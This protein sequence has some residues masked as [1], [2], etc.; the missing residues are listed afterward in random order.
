[1]IIDASAIVAITLHEPEREAFLEKISA[2]DVVLVPGPTLVEAGIVLSAR[3]A[4]DAGQL[5]AEALTT[6]DATVIEFGA[7]HW[8][9]AISAW[10]RFGKGRHPA[11]LNFGDCLVYAAA[12]VARQP[13]L[14]KGN[15]F[16]LTDIQLA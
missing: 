15:D 2:A 10:W 16:P 9:E 11:R 8:R 5:L 4:D 12:R 1:M 6:I 13:L 14:A 7:D 3:S